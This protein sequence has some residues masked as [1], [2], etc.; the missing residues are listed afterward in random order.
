MGRKPTLSSARQTDL[1]AFCVTREKLLMIVGRN[2]LKSFIKRSLRMAKNS[3]NKVI[4]KLLRDNP[5]VT[6]QT[7]KVIHSG[8]AQAQTEATLLQHFDI[9]KKA[10][11]L[12]KE[13][14][15]KGIINIGTLI[16]PTNKL[17]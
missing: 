17:L 4:K 8:R 2:D 12:L 5:K 7:P 15:V 6:L 3:S 14:S 13:Y 10:H 9:M 16:I 1:A 11:D